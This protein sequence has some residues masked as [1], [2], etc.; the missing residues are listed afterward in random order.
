M[1]HIKWFQDT[2]AHIAFLET[3]TF[4]SNIWENKDMMQT[5]RVT[6]SLNKK[7]YILL[8]PRK[9]NSCL[10]S[11]G[12]PQLSTHSTTT[13]QLLHAG[14]YYPSQTLTARNLYGHVWIWCVYAALESHTIALPLVKVPYFQVLLLVVYTIT[15]P[16][17]TQ[18]INNLKTAQI[19]N[20]YCSVVTGSVVQRSLKVTGCAVVQWNEQQLENNKAKVIHLGNQTQVLHPAL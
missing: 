18:K 10:K 4:L 11:G 8:S 20:K 1:Y 3:K 19:L 17:S 5:A 14:Y 12:P 2:S 7:Y 15:A 9:H 16:Q 6:Q 13:S